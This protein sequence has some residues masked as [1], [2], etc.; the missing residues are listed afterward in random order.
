MSAITERQATEKFLTDPEFH[1]RVMT[2]VTL[3]EWTMRRETGMETTPAFRAGFIQAC[4]YGLFVGYAPFEQMMMDRE[5]AEASMRAHAQAMGM[6]VGRQ[7]I[8]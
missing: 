2:A 6:S 7:E 3:T 5:Q 1:A 8:K 4:C